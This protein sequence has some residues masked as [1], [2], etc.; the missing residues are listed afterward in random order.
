MI[1]RLHFQVSVVGKI[2]DLIQ[3]SWKIVPMDP[4]DNKFALDQ[5]M[6]WHQAEATNH[7]LN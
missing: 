7:Y 1:Y 5:L 2:C 6:D 4:L 3:I